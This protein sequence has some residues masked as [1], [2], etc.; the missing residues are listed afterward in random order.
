M[1]NS[2]SPIEF[3]IFR[4]AAAGQSPVVVRWPTDEEW[5][6]N[7]R[8]RK[9]IMQS[10]GRGTSEQLPVDTG[11]AD[12]KLYE[13][14][15]LNGAPPLTP[16]EA[17]RVID[18]IAVCDVIGNELGAAEAEVELQIVTGEARHKLKVP[19]IDMVKDVQ[20]T[21][22]TLNLQYGRFEIRANIEN[23][24]RLWDKCL[25]EVEGY[26]GP[27][28]IIHKDIVIRAVINAIELEV[29]PKRDENF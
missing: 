4:T 6:P 19:T 24:A 14:I 25:I 9:I 3:P 10:L 5:I 13:S 1:F 23:Y 22:R 29:A 7:R 28:P 18:A 27:V 15:K 8:A 16:G 11:A 2:E 12:L 20:K 17:T 26:E 21:N